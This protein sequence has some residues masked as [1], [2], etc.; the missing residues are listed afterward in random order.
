[1]RVCNDDC[2][3]WFGMHHHLLRCGF[4]S[5]FVISMYL[6]ILREAV[7]TFLLQC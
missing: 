2:G 6:E 3:I 4:S 7:G 1:M 5:S